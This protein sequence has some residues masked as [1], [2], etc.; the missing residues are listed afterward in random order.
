[1]KPLLD[2]LKIIDTDYALKLVCLT[3]FRFD[4]QMHVFMSPTYERSRVLAKE[5]ETLVESVPEWAR[6]KITTKRATE[7]KFE[8]NCGVKFVNSS[9]HCKALTMNT[10]FVDVD[11]K[12]EDIEYIMPCLA[13]GTTMM[14]I[15]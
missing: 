4:N 2:R 3:C 1:M 7:F 8:N 11:Y 14:R 10:L 6:V 13:Y 5:F 9:V 15:K 12:T